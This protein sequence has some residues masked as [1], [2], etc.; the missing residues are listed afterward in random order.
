VSPRRKVSVCTSLSGRDCSQQARKAANAFSQGTDLVEF[1][2]DMLRRPIY[3]EI[4]AAV[5]DFA[6]RFVLTVRSRVEGGKFDGPESE[7]IALIRKLV[8][9]KPAFFD[10]ELR[11]LESNP[12]LASLSLGHSMIV[13]SHNLSR[14]PDRRSILRTKGKA[15]S[16][17]GLVKVVPTATNA[18]DNLTILSLYD[19]PGP[20]PIAF[21]M[22]TQGLFSRVMAMERG[23][24]VTYAS[25]SSEE[26]APGQLPL[27]QVLAIRRRLENA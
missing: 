11:T 17:G 19:E 26:T 6:D 2:I 27:R 18:A 9:L 16:Y 5:S 13:S 4:R 1:R 24:P 7:R 15:A 14:T 22:G 8:D 23:S 10:V 20:P 25:L 21:C 3:N 12:D